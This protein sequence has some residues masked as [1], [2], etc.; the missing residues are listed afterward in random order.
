M[1]QQLMQ[2]QMAQLQQR[3]AAKAEQGARGQPEEAEASCLEGGACSKGFEE[4]S[5]VSLHVQPLL[6]S[7]DNDEGDCDLVENVEKGTGQG[8]ESEGLGHES[9]GLSH[10]SEGLSHESEG[11]SHG[12]EGLATPQDHDANEKTESM[13]GEEVEGGSQ[14]GGAAASALRPMSPASALMAKW[15]SRRRTSFAAGATGH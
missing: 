4:K 5:D 12:S 2:N 8:H 9:E 6:R 11:L 7:A 15:S 1:W 3:I 13:N 14:E 10:E